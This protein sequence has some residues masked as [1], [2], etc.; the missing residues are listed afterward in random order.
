MITNIYRISGLVLA[1]VVAALVF[2]ANLSVYGPMIQADEGSYLASAAAIAGFPNDFASSYHAGYSILIAPAFWLA[3]TPRGIWT[4]VKA[5]NAVLILIAVLSLWW[6]AGLLKPEVGHWRRL[7][8]V[9]L[10]SFY[11]MWVVLAGYC[12]AQIAFVPVF[13]LL[14]G[15]YLHSIKGGAIVWMTSGLLAGFLYWIHPMAVAVLIAVLIATGYVA[16]RRRSFGL[17]AVL[18]GTIV[19]MVLL[20]QYGVTPWLFDRMTISGVQPNLHYPSIS[21]MVSPLL[22]LNGIKD[23]LTRTGGL[24][25][26]MTIGTIGLLWGGLFKVTHQALR[27]ARSRG[28][29]A[30]WRERA[31]AAFLWLSLLGSLGLAA[32]FI[33]SQSGAQRLD[34]W[35]YGRYAEGVIAPILLVAALGE[36]Y[37]KALWAVPIAVACA[38]LLWMGLD[39][40]THIAY[41]NISS[42]WQAFLL[43]D[44]G[45]WVWLATGCMLIILAVVIPRRLAILLIAGIFAFSNHLQIRWHDAAAYNAASRWETAVAVRDWYPPGTCVGFDH[46]G[47]DSYS[48]A[49]FWFDFGFVLYD[50][51]LKRIDVDSW[52][53]SCDG[54]LFSYDME[55]DDLD[56]NVHLLAISPHGGPLLW[57]KGP[58][59][60]G[61]T[62]DIYVL[63]VD[64][65]DRRRMPSQV[66]RFDNGVLVTTGN[67]GF[68]VYGPYVPVNA[69]EYRLVVNGAASSVASA[70]VDV[71]SG[72]IQHAKFPLSETQES[73]TGVLAS[74]LVVLDNSV[75]DL[76][77][78]VFVGAEDE[79]RLEGYELVPVDTNVEDTGSL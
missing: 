50:Y 30:S 8:A 70:W 78:R 34:H 33:S 64:R 38:G 32:L 42:F 9:G 47:I 53:E 11:P 21:E 71:A 67:A 4:A 74:G 60:S 69:G 27:G 52:L 29:C 12:F 7:A 10:V 6:V 18:L 65:F 39:T 43:L 56:P 15:V 40:Y 3:D 73:E 68:L 45:L 31:I 48:R 46:S 41:F 5:I 28:S 35:M 25:F 37:R 2:F 36:S 58:L 62:H 20:Y 49:V 51:E 59:P 55:L 79:V 19:G 26:Y 75:S 1:V 63:R 16:Y 61:K 54:P 72:S 44:Q 22:T 57:G 76:E 23:I 24:M 14:F 13:I 17:F 66:G 77:V